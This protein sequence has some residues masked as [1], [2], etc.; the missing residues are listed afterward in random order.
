ME[1]N[2]INLFKKVY[3]VTLMSSKYFKLALMEQ[4]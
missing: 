2:Q 4:S 3:D 1:W